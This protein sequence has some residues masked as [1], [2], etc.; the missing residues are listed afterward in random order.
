LSQ[1]AHIIGL[2]IGAVIWAVVAL[3]VIS[4]AKPQEPYGFGQTLWDFKDDAEKAQIKDDAESEYLNA[5][6]PC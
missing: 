4:D 3:T 2:V 6:F 1:Q 5:R